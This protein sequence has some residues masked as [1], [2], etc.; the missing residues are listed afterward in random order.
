[1]AAWYSSLAMTDIED[2]TSEAPDHPSDAGTAPFWVLLL[3]LIIMIEIGALPV[4]RSLIAAVF[5]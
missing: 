3:V 1:M 4:T 2:T 5:R